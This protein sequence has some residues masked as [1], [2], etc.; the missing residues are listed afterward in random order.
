MRRMEYLKVIG[1][2]ISPFVDKWADQFNAC[3]LILFGKNHMQNS[4]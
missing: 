1:G 3:R 4:A 2:G